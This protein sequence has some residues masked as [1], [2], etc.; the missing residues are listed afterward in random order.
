MAGQDGVPTADI[1]EAAAPA[2]APTNGTVL[3]AFRLGWHVSERHAL[4]ADAPERPGETGDA[5]LPSASRLDAADRLRLLTEA[6]RVDLGALAGSAGS[7]P[8]LDPAATQPQVYAFHKLLLEALT[9][10]DYRLGKAYS[11]G[12]RLA[13][14]SKRP[15]GASELREALAPVQLDETVGWLEDLRCQFPP[16]ATHAVKATLLDWAAWV[17]VPGERQVDERALARL[18]EQGRLWRA[19]LS[20]EKDACHLL[21]PD[22]YVLAARNLGHRLGHLVR[23]TIWSAWGAAAAVVLAVIGGGGYLLV[24]SFHHGSKTAL[25]ITTI[26]GGL[27]ISWKGISATLGR[28]IARV[29]RPIWEAEL[30]ESIAAA[31]RRLPS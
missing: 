12:A 27:G 25:A 11:L 5:T 28:S 16:Y 7:L 2:E 24:H 30:G 26:V 6:I 20:G 4:D 31:A 22:D 15:S 18:Q 8:S 19:L 10:A 1:V 21:R 17:D 9:A 3:A 29:E 13:D 14:V 23:R